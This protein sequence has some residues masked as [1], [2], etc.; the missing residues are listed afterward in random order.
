MKVFKIVLVIVCLVGFILWWTNPS[1]KDFMDHAP[2]VL[3]VER[4]E[5][6][7]KKGWKLSHERTKNNIFY[8]YYRFSYGCMD[9]YDSYSKWKIRNFKQQYYL[10]IFNNF[11]RIEY[12][13]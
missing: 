11:Y 13:E 6:F 3:I 7:C 4:Q 9:K 8:S 12:L 10:G 5:G 1:L 2:T